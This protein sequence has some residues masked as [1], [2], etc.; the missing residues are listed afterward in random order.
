MI[1]AQMIA[2]VVAGLAGL[3]VLVWLL[4]KLG[5][6]L[7]GKQSRGRANGTTGSA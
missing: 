6:A 2:L 7:T 4:A 5:K 3:G 1:D